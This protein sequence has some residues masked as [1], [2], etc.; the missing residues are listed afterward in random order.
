MA[1][2]LQIIAGPA[3]TVSQANRMTEWQD[4]ELNARKERKKKIEGKWKRARWEG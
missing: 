1:G 4:K 3:V 2:K